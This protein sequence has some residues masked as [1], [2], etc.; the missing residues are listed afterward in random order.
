MGRGLEW[1][2]A[3]KGNRDEEARS[4]EPG[5]RR[6][7]KREEKSVS[8]MRLYGTPS[9]D[10]HSA[11]PTLLHLA[12]ADTH[13]P[14]PPLGSSF[15]WIV[16]GLLQE[17]FQCSAYCSHCSSEF[18]E[19]HQSRSFILKPRRPSHYA[20]VRLAPLVLCSCCALG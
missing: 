9:A 3:V 5:R 7:R 8:T 6:V 16:G 15:G 11:L 10:P 20:L 17:E 19:A 13:T 12:S 1:L 14:S 18:Y 2:G 4:E